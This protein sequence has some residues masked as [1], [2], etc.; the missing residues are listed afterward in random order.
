MRPSH[1]P[2]SMAEN[3]THVPDAADRTTR[4]VMRTPT[5]IPA[6]AASASIRKIC[7]KCVC[8][9]RVEFGS[10]ARGWQNVGGGVVMLS[11][12]CGDGAEEWFRG[13]GV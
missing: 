6:A 12:V 7:R 10:N 5:N 3:F 4:H 1:I 11:S 8:A 2:N 13:S 9:M